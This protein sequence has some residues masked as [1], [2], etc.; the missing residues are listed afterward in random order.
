MKQ[1]SSMIVGCA[2]DRLEHAADAD[3]AGQVHV[4]ADLGAAADRRPG[5]D[6]RAAVHVGADVDVGGHQHD[7]AGDVGA[8]PGDGR[9]HDADTAAAASSASLQ[10]GELERHL[11]VEVRIPG[12]DPPALRRCRNTAGRPS[13]A[14]G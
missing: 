6:H 10:S 11:V 12:V 3:A 14:T 4:L 5:V 7:A 13:S 2:C 1:L 9:R 8:A